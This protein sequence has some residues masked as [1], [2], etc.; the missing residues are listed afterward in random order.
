M[1]IL[2]ACVAIGGYLLYLYVKYFLQ[3]RENAHPLV[4]RAK[5]GLPLLG[6]ALDFLPGSFLQTAE[7]Y[8]KLYGGFVEFFVLWQRGIL[9]SDPAI[10]K[11]CMMASPKKFRRF[12]A[13]DYSTDVNGLS[14]GLFHSNGKTWSKVRKATAPSFSNQNMAAKFPAVAQEVKAWTER[15]SEQTTAVDMTVESM[16][17][18]L[19]VITV[20]AFGLGVADPVVGYFLSEH[21]AQDIHDIFMFMVKHP[22]FPFPNWVWRLSPL[23]AFELRARAA[24][25][26]FQRH[27]STILSQKKRLLDPLH[28]ASMIEH[29]IVHGELTDEEIISNVKIFYMAGAETTAITLTWA[30]FYLC[31][32]AH[33]MDKL[34]HEVVVLFAAL[35]HEDCAAIS[36]DAVR[37]MS[38]AN[39]VVKEAL[40]LAPPAFFLG[41]ELE[42]GIESHEL[43]NGIKVRR[44]DVIRMNLG[45]MLLLDSAYPDTKAFNPDRWLP[46]A[47]GL[48]KAEDSWL[49]FGFGPR[50]CPGMTLA[51]TEAVLA[52]AMLAHSFDMALDCPVEEIK[53]I[54]V[55][56]ASSNK[57]PIRFT[58]RK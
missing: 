19:R 20:V 17:L 29:L 47:A 3:Q 55:F 34:R 30:C 13:T 16:S 14:A 57:M 18:T 33:V 8:P 36:M 1:L 54:V 6:N 15:L 39:A 24:N 43:S 11:E 49:P 22:F 38:Y 28:P 27:C 35:G 56:A 46:G 12:R 42:D 51:L 2:L 32:N 23:H 4:V 37:G 52:V 10:A 41:L 40:R 25:D 58:K 7:D 21:Y 45:G 48:E 50:I 31:Q 53:R 44:G 9:V 26:R 5:G